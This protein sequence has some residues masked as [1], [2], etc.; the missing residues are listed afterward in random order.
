MT[1]RKDGRWQQRV[2]LTVSGRPVSRYFY[3]R[4]K[5]EVLRKINAWTAEVERGRSFQAVADEWWAITMDELSP[6]SVKGYR[7]ACRRACEYFGQTP[8]RE[9]RPVDV[10]KYI[11]EFV[12]E[13]NPAEKTT[14]TQLL[15]VN[16]ICRHALNCGDIDS[17]PVVGVTVPKH[18]PRGTRE[19]PTDEDLRRVKES[20]DLP[21]G[22]FALWALYTGCRRGELLA[23]TWE[24]VDLRARTVEITKSV[25]YMGNSPHVKEPKTM[26]GVRTVPI[27]NALYRLIKDQRG[28]GPI[29]PDPDTG[30]LMRES[31]FKRLWKAYASASG[32]NVTPHQ[33]RH[34]FA[35]MLFEAGVAPKDA[36]ELLGHSNLSTTEEIYTHLRDQRRALIRRQLL[37]VDI[38]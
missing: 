16:L 36:Q 25:Y 13:H 18:L 2:T 24:D 29:F 3:G 34:T 35:T 6:N 33:L 19:I 23:L 10:R 22:M 5:A 26:A 9:L 28:S 14:R 38:A 4:T 37:D 12:R 20:A 11:T 30:G 17:N 7:P 27:L 21:F 8:I 15:I 1:R 32:V 31:T